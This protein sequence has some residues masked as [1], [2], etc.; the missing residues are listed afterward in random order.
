[1]S[2]QFEWDPLKDSQNQRKHQVSFAEAAFV[3]ADF[4]SASM[5]DPDHSDTE[6]RY[7]IIGLS[8]R[9]RPLMVSYTERGNYIRIISARKLTSTER[10][11]YEETI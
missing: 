10:K 2:L 6:D 11:Q 8:N 1:M 9:A 4:L 3:F 7:I 5:P